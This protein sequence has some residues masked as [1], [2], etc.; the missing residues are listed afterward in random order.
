MKVQILLSCYHINTIDVESLIHRPQMGDE[1]TCMICHRED[2]YIL[3]VG[4]VYDN[5]EEKKAIHG[6]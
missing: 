4:R 3:R 1:K 2:V 5:D 6:K